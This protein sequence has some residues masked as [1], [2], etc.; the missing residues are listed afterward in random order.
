MKTSRSKS[1]LFVLCLIFA[2][3]AA[4][5]YSARGQKQI[6]P[7][8]TVIPGFQGINKTGPLTVSGK[9]T[10]NKILQ[11]SEGRVN[12]ALTLR[13]EDET[14]IVSGPFNHVDM[15][16]VLDRSGSMKGSK[17]SDA[18]RAVLK[19]L[20]RLSP[21]DRFAL[22][23]YSD[24]VQQFSGLRAVTDAYRQQMGAVIQR[25]RPGGGTNLGA[26]LQAG[27]DLLVSAE[28]NKNSGKVI[29]I[30]DGLAN[31]GIRD[32]HLLGNIA[33]IAMGKE[34]A[35]STVGVGV[36][37]NEVLM[38][39]IADQGAGNY[40]YLENPAAFADVFQKE[41][42]A[43]RNTAVTGVSV[44]V[45]LE[46]GIS[47]VHASGYPITLENRHAVFHP[48]NLRADQTRKIFLTFRIPSDTRGSFEIEGIE[49][50]YFHNGTSFTT[51]LPETFQIACIKDPKR[52]LLSI[53]KSVW[54]DQVIYED[55]NRL[56]QEVAGDIKAGKKARALDRID[57]Y[58]Q[59]KKVLNATVASEAVA[60][61]LDEDVKELEQRV[62]G[63]FQGSPSAVL[64]KQKSS[65]KA[66]QYEGYRG[67]RQ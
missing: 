12:L 66:L 15:V 6:L 59:E 62:K 54:S 44:R 17:I 52:V 49:V 18:R 67:R 28:P 37:F 42:Y 48:G 56:K 51:T 3:G 20:A 64:E 35:V 30:S 11:G 16:V 53:D 13:S 45:P 2:T 39:R 60:E 25:I 32:P 43:T 58:R 23:T 19:L 61:N 8:T 7:G 4:M 27:L 10:Q 5:A 1:I 50:R 65:A 38:T 21:K 24:G 47:L 14:D 55:Y 26:G 63:T 40:Y 36:D 9:L 57:K 33:K 31:K 41:F 46:S 22:V 34:F 29:L